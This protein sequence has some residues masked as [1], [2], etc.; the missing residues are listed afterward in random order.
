V[1]A[2]WQIIETR[3]STNAQLAVQTF[4]KIRDPKIKK[5]LRDIIY[6]LS[7]EEIGHLSTTEKMAIGDLLD[8]FDMIGALID[9]G[10]IDESCAIEG[11]GGGPAV[12]RCWYQLAGYIRTEQKVRG[13]YAENYEDFTYRTYKHYKNANIRIALHT[14]NIDN[15]LDEYDKSEFETLFPR[16]S[17][18]I[19]KQRRNKRGV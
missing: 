8:W 18:I 6:E 10:I 15:L 5:L 9:K 17:K 14:K 2:I 16:S 11:Y 13:S 12:L 3:K 19:R 4:T 1:F 7:P